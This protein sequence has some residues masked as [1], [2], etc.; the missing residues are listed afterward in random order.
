MSSHAHEVIDKYVDR[1]TKERKNAGEH[2]TY[3]GKRAEELERKGKIR[4]IKS[5]AK[6]KE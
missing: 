5:E 1:D 3:K 2:V 4:P 6:A